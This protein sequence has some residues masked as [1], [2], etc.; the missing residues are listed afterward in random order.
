MGRKYKN[1]AKQKRE[2]KLR[3][4]GVLPKTE[5]P[6]AYKEI[7]KENEKFIRYYKHMNICPAD[8]WDSFI[9]TLQSDL[10]TTFR[11]SS[12]QNTADKLLDIVENQ[13]FKKHFGD[14]AASDVERPFPLPWYPNNLAWQLNVTRKH[15]RRSESLYKFHNFLMA[16]TEAGS[17]SRQEAVSMI[18][19]IVLDVKPH[20]KVLDT[21]A[22]PGSKTA[23][24]I[25]ALHADGTGSVPSGFVIANDVCSDEKIICEKKSEFEF[26]WCFICIIFQGQQF[27]MLHVGSPSEATQHSMFHCHQSGQHLFAETENFG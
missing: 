3:N 23:Q 17:I 9:E 21:C 6:A 10:P 7:I 2:R 27:K 24:I 16:E 4:E 5:R 11:F 1:F 13:F 22:A 8:E 12:S 14:D 15:I 26:D 19:P 18:P 25:E 20:H